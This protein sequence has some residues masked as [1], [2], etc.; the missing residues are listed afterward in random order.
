VLGINLC[1][2]FLI[3]RE[4]EFGLPRTQRNHRGR[5]S[6]LAKVAGMAG[7]W[8][9]SGVRSQRSNLECNQLVSAGDQFGAV[10]VVVF[11]RSTGSVRVFI[12]GLVLHRARGA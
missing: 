10:L 11:F 12:E 7:Y 9:Y 6:H 2:A 1:R 5:F 4:D 3:L 8:G